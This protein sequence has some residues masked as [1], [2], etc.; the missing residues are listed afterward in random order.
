MGRRV[1]FFK[2]LIMI[3]FSLYLSGVKR[4]LEGG[5]TISMTVALLTARIS[6][7]LFFEMF[8]AFVGFVASDFAAFS[9]RNYLRLF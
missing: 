3:G 4:L 5:Y 7:F 6:V 1:A 8:N 9:F 2:F